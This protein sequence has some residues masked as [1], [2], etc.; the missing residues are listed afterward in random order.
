[1]T[2]FP[3]LM[4]RYESRNSKVQMICIKCIESIFYGRLNIILWLDIETDYI[5]VY[6]V[7]EEAI[8]KRDRRPQ[9]LKTRGKR[10]WR[11]PRRRR[12]SIRLMCLFCFY[13]SINLL[14]VIFK[15]LTLI[16]DILWWVLCIWTLADVH[17][18]I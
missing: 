10:L 8:E 11:Q 12:H 7:E 3:L 1:M 16:Q 9:P 15:S 13:P 17:F 14:E 18:S 2:F 5:L 4:T 6:T